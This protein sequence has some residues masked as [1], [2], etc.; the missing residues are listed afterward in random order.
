MLDGKTITLEVR[1]SDSIEDLKAKIQHREGFPPHT[2][3]LIFAG[4]PL[5]D[6]RTLSDYHIRNEYTLHFVLRLPGGS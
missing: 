3:R 6:G 4:K 1:P 2:Q 5:Q